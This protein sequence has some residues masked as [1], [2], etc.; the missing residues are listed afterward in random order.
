MLNTVE[1]AVAEALMR[2]PQP[3]GRFTTPHIFITAAEN[4]GM[5]I[6]PLVIRSN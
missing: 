1:A 2:W 6:P 4:E 3:D 5:I